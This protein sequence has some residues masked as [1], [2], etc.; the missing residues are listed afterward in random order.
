MKLHAGRPPDLADPDILLREV[1]VETRRAAAGLQ[2][3]TQGAKPMA[4]EADLYLIK[5]YARQ[6]DR[7]IGLTR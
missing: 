5:R 4:A 2:E 7:D 3:L 6:P 1:G